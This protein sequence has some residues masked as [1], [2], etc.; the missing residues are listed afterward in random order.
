MRRNHASLVLA[1]HCN[2]LLPC[3]YDVENQATRLNP[4]DPLVADLLTSGWRLMKNPLAVATDSDLLI[5]LAKLDVHGLANSSQKLADWSYWPCS[6]WF[7][8]HHF[9]AVGLAALPIRSLVSASTAP[10]YPSHS[11]EIP[12]RACFRISVQVPDQSL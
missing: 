4:E 7:R 9:H 6:I 5:G 8:M 12:P 10:I 3:E 2:C 1:G 11:P